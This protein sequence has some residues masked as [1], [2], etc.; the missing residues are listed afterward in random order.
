MRYLRFLLLFVISLLSLSASAENIVDRAARKANSAAALTAGF[1]V[2]GK[3]ASLTVSG[4]RYAIVSPD[5]KIYYDGSTQWTYVP[6]DA[7]VTLTRPT[8]DE[9]AQ[10]NPLAI[11]TTLRHNFK[12]VVQGNKATFTPKDPAKSDVQRIVATFDSTTSW[13]VSVSVTSQGQTIR[14]TDIRVTA[15][16]TQPAASAFKFTAPKGITIIDLR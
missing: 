7:E 2:D 3:R 9:Q 4:V 15:G 13:P 5:M 16:S 10:V 14:V 8:A 11:L 1:V 6:A 12:V